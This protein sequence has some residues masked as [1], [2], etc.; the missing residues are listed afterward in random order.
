MASL[1]A[2][3]TH[4]IP[5]RRTNK[6]K[7]LPKGLVALSSAQTELLLGLTLLLLIAGVHAILAR[8]GILL[9]LMIGAFFQGL[10]YLAAPVLALLAEWDIRSKPANPSKSLK[11]LMGRSE[12]EIE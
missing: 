4:R 11:K 2:I 3:F 12:A 1:W 9:M 5:W 10:R 8:R 6:F 7:A